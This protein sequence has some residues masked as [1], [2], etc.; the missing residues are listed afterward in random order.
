MWRAANTSSAATLCST[1]SSSVLDGS[2][3]VG[4]NHFGFAVEDREEIMRRIKELGMEAPKKRPSDR[5][6][7]EY[8]ACD[9]EGNF[10]DI[11]QHGFDMV[12]TDADRAKRKV[13]A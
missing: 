12:E 11:S 4:L 7:A 5:P 8:R 3:P 10:F 6:F 1:S 2:A 9:P 13:P